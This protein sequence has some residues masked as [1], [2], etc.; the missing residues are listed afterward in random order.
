MQNFKKLSY[1]DLKRIKQLSVGAEKNLHFQHW[2]D[3]LFK[4]QLRKQHLLPIWQCRN[5]GGTKCSFSYFF[6]KIYFRLR[7]HEKE[8]R[9]FVFNKIQFC[10]NFRVNNFV[11]PL[12]RGPI[13]LVQQFWAHY[14][15][16]TV[17]CRPPWA[18]CRPSTGP[19]HAPLRHQCPWRPTN[20]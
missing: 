1:P 3:L 2:L 14:I 15:Y 16:Y 10:R 20:R 7:E 9:D 8:L 12:A 17:Y 5:R 6:A 4:N 19:F 18:F 11:S 13:N